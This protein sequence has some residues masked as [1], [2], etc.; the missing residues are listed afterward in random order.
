MSRSA[1]FLRFLLVAALAGPGLAPPAAAQQSSADMGQVSHP[2]TY[3]ALS[4]Y[5]TT[6]LPPGGD[7]QIRNFRFRGE[8]ESLVAQAEARVG[9]VPGLELLGGLGWQT[10]TASGPVRVLEPGV[11]GWDVRTMSLGGVPIMYGV[12]SPMIQRLTRRRDTMVP[13]P[14]AP[15]VQRV[16]VDSTGLL[17][18]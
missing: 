18:Q 3:D 13:V 4:Q 8:G 14:V 9:S 6:M 2:L 16:V 12:W 11:V 7:Q 1:K 10:V 17:L 15:W 5:M